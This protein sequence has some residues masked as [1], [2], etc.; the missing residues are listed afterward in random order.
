MTSLPSEAVHVGDELADMPKRQHVLR[1]LSNLPSL[2]EAARKL[3]PGDVFRVVMSEGNA[4]LFKKAADGTFKP[5]LR[6]S[7]K[8]VENADL[9]RLPPDYVGAVSNFALMLNMAAIAAKLEAIEVG[10]RNIGRLIADTQRGRV[11]GTLDALALAR[12]LSDPAECRAQMIS[13]C[14]DVVV[15]MGAL[16]GQLRSHIA[17]M[18]KETTGLFEGFVGSGLAEAT[19]AYEQVEDDVSLLIRGFRALLLAYQDLGEPAM[20]RE[21]LARIMAGTRACL[22]DAIRKARLVPVPEKGIARELYLVSFLDVVALMDAR[23][24][25][26]GRE[27]RAL[28]SMDI[29]PEELQG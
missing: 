10:V 12:A 17:A 13:A 24:F 27:D 7:G 19:A 5:Y 15:E 14:S 26:S 8:F 11:N 6:E 16:T 20:A 3:T 2:V 23:L 21:A 18:P 1:I 29:K 25:S 22:P 28:I 9:M 4:H